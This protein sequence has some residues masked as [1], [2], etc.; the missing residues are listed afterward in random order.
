M[1]TDSIFWVPAP[2]PAPIFC[3]NLRPATRLETQD[4]DLTKEIELAGPINQFLPL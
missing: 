4:S 2:A 3:Q 1:L